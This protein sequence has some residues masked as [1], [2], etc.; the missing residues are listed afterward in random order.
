M[1]FTIPDWAAD[2]FVRGHFIFSSSRRDFW[3]WSTICCCWLRRILE[4]VRWWCCGL[5]RQRHGQIA[6]QFSTLVFS[7]VSALLGYFKWSILQPGLSDVHMY[8]KWKLVLEVSTDMYIFIKFRWDRS[9]GI[10]KPQIQ[11]GLLQLL[12]N[13][14]LRFRFGDDNWH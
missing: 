5:S 13:A 8:G 7:I 1:E 11:S 6:W 2:V 10:I 3:R 9:G 14:H 12:P 4:T